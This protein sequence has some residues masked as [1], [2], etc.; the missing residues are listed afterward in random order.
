MENCD[1]KVR[2]RNL[3]V[4]LMS[5]RRR[6]SVGIVDGIEKVLI[7]NLKTTLRDLKID[8]DVLDPEVVINDSVVCCCY[9]RYLDYGV[10][11]H[12]GDLL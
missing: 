2:V 11:T 6:V 1:Y 12:L 10:Y 9:R 7:E 4:V 5:H 8:L 3:R